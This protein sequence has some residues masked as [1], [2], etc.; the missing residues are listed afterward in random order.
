[1]ALMSV[2]IGMSM[3]IGAFLMGIVVSQAKSQSIIE[4]D[5]TPMKDI[6][7]AMFFIS[8]GLEIKPSDIIDNIGLIMLIFVVYAILKSSTVFLA[9]FI[10]DKS[11]RLSFMSAVSLVAMGEFAFIIAKVGLDEGVLPPDIYASVICA[12]LVSMVVLPLLSLKSS[13]IC[14]V[15]YD[16]APK[17]VLNTVRRVEAVRN[18]HYSKIALASKSTS[19]RFRE[20]ATMAYIDVLLLIGIEIVFFIFTPGMTNFLYNNMGSLS[21]QMCYTIVLVVNFVA[22]AIPLY[23]LIKNLKFVEKV[24]IETERRAETKGEGSLQR[25]T[26]KF[27]RAFVRINNWALVFLIAFVILILVPNSIGLVEHI[28]AMLGGIGVILLI[29]AYKHKSSTG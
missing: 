20:R 15:V 21:Y 13:E 16:H 9:Y 3:A 17:P 22:I 4:H 19:S 26:I 14:D 7:M 24:L 28:L 11:I 5:I 23:D 27:H 18:R 1:M 29:Y 10:G 6:F 8:V 2:W 25:R 12:A